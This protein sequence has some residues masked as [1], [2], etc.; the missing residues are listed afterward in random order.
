MDSAVKLIDAIADLL[1]AIAWPAAVAVIAIY[2]LRGHRDAVGGVFDRAKSV[3]LPGGAQ[4]DLY[5]K[6]ERQ[7][8]QHVIDAANR[9]ADV[10]PEEQRS[11]AEDLLKEF[12]RH[13]DAMRLVEVMLNKGRSRRARQ[14]AFELLTTVF[15]AVFIDGDADRVLRTLDDI[16]NIAHPSRLGWMW[17]EIEAGPNVLW[18]RTT[19]PRGVAPPPE[20]PQHL[21]PAPG[22]LPRHDHIR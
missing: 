17:D 11:A 2:V 15:N 16:D 8:E 3:V 21:D 13:D 4:I 12:T 20:G 1:G 9:V 5:E 7:S 14:L 19:H 22:T 6:L 18:D 10:P